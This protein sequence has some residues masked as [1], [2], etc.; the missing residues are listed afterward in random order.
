MIYIKVVEKKSFS[1]AAIEMGL[2]TGTVSKSVTNLEAVVNAQLLSRNAHKFEVTADGQIVYR[3]ALKLC[4]TYYNLLAKLDGHN[5]EIKGSMR[6]SAP[7]VLC[8]SIVSNWIM[9]YSEKN[10]STAIHLISRE[11]ASFTCDSPE[12]D[13]LVIKSGYMESPDL[14]HKKLNPVPFGIFAAPAYLKRYTRIE[15]PEDLNGHQILKLNHPSL[16]YPL[17]M[18]NK[19]VRKQFDLLLCKEIS[20]NNVRSLL[21]MT[22][23]GKGI[24][25]AAP[26][27]SVEG[28]LREGSLVEV[29]DDWAL[30]PLPSYLVWRYR[31][32][33]SPLFKDFI[34]FI[35]KKWNA[36]FL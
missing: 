16:K 1:A 18:K 27:W 21:H 14:I 29:L 33:Y 6:L 4:G 20:S 22:V 7:G 30:Q 28:F 36:F 3:E 10:S 19:G 23:N 2:S 24:C 13:D 32:W 9:E 5:N 8:D 34:L 11:G 12:F 25:V 35:E 31:K 15:T 26:R 17:N